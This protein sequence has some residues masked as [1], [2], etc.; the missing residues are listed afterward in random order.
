MVGVGI[1][2]ANLG[3]TPRDAWW[4][5]PRIGSVE[6]PIV[7]EH[8]RQLR[9]VA[10]RSKALGNANGVVIEARPISAAPPEVLNQS[11]GGNVRRYSRI[12]SR[13]RRN[14]ARLSSCEPTNMAGSSKQRWILT[15]A[16]GKT[17][18]LSLALSQTVRT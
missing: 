16:P 5:A 11:P 9:E 3:Y 17:G 12:S 8:L 14:N 18:Q 2:L 1:A 10:I 15:A 7:P 6:L 4:G 13:T